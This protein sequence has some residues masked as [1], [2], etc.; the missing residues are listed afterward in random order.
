M[1]RIS[2][3]AEECLPGKYHADFEYQAEMEREMSI[4][5][6]DALFLERQFPLKG[7]V[8][9]EHVKTGKKGYVPVEFISKVPEG[10]Y[11]MWAYGCEIVACFYAFFSGLFI[12]LYGSAD[13]DSAVEVIMGAAGMIL[14][15]LL[16]LMVF[17]REKVPAQY[18]A[19]CLGVVSIPLFAGYPW[20]IWGGVVMLLAA[21]VELLKWNAA[22]ENFI[23]TNL[24]VKDCCEGM[25]GASWISI[26][27]FLLWL[28][29][30]FAVFLLGAEYGNRR[31]EDWSPQY[32]MPKGAWAFAAGMASCI[33]FQIVV[34]MVFGLQGFQELLILSTEFKAQRVGK[35]AR[36]KKVLKGAFSKDSLIRVNRW[37]AY[38][39]LV[40]IFLHVFGVFATYN[41]SG[42]AKDY[43]EIFGDAPTVTGYTLLVLLAVILS[44]A[45]ISRYTAPVLLT[46]VQRTGVAFVIVTIFHGKD[47]WAPNMWKYLI[48]PAV[49]YAMDFM[50]RQGLLKFRVKDIQ[51]FDEEADT[52]PLGKSNPPPLP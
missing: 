6:G 41:E 48:V 42:P 36:L 30:N 13:V 31:A 12:L 22:D 4:A 39:M 44:S 50:F 7:W 10:D 24:D 47:W 43:E 9:A 25:W 20:G 49:L 45:W 46:N 18:R 38:T 28:A 51:D 37:I 17:F 32:E 21:C 26:F 1:S 35:K 34:M 52:V 19:G 11:D 3:V 40:C 15:S 33:C 16:M 23:P 5:A 27:F 8:L 2:S 14:A 29:A